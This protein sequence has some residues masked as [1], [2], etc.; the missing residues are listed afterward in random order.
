MLGEVRLP[1]R[2]V[3][4]ATSAQGRL[5]PSEFMVPDVLVTFLVFKAVLSVDKDPAS[6]PVWLYVLCHTTGTL[7][8]Q[9]AVWM[10]LKISGTC[11]HT[12]PASVSSGSHSQHVSDK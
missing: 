12:G 10:S 9:D 4:N 7:R 2:G 1:I 3:V 5:L 6:D 8:C 11:S